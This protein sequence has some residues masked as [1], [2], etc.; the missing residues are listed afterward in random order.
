MR[1]SDDAE[2]RG[3]N[4]ALP[5]GPDVRQGVRGEGHG[6]FRV[7]GAVVRGV[8]NGGGRPEVMASGCAAD[9]PAPES[10]E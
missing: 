1:G 3:E 2:R 9:G 7:Q 4:A 8:Q 6:A 10:G 5:G